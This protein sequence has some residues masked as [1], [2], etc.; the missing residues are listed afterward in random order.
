MGVRT[1]IFALLVTA[2]TVSARGD[3]ENENRARATLQRMNSVATAI[4]AYLTDADTAPAATSVE[5]L[6]SVLAPTYITNVPTRDGWDTPLRYV[7]TGDRSF[8]IISAGSDQKFDEKSWSVPAR[9]KDF[10]DDAVFTVRHLHPHL[11][12][13]RWPTAGDDGC[14]KHG[15]AA[16]RRQ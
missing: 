3:Q 1:V 13:F 12:R 4:E 8:R 7:K 6:Q 2:A 9:T 11:D 16:P 10:A 5:A 14:G 15:G